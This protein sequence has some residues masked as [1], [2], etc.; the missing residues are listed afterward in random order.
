MTKLAMSMQR[1][2]GW[3][4]P[5][6][7]VILSCTKGNI[8]ARDKNIHLHFGETL[9]TTQPTSPTD[10]SPTFLSFV[11]LSYTIDNII[12]RT[13]HAV[14]MLTK[15]LNDSSIVR[16]TSLKKSPMTCVKNTYS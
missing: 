8:V 2:K 13:L 10:L 3:K 9:I 16:V 14:L 15:K 6:G 11:T 7:F 4:T 12:A 5:P 1:G